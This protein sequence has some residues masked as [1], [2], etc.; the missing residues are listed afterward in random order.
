M[1]KSVY[2]VAAAAIVAGAFVATLSASGRGSV[3]DIEA[4]RTDIRPL[5]RS[6]LCG[7]PDK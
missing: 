3:P 7:L 6:L 2:A 5:A 4:D 1:L